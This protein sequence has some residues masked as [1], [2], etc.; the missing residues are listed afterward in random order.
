MRTGSRLAAV[1]LAAAVWVYAGMSFASMPV[2]QQAIAPSVL[3]V[4]ASA[5]TAAVD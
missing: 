4:A 5:A 3:D 1:L 2:T